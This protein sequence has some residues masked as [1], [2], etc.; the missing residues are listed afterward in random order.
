M[1]P[2]LRMLKAGCRWRRRRWGLERFGRRPRGSDVRGGLCAGHRRRWRDRS[3]A[4]ET[5]RAGGAVG[6]APAVD[7]IGVGAGTGEAIVGDEVGLVV[8][9]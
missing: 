3:S 8:E 2:P 6:E 1:L 4:A 7:E 9:R 5:H